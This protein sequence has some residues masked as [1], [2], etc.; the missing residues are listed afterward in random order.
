MCL[1][2]ERFP[3]DD[4][5]I[6]REIT[7]NSRVA[8]IAHTPWRI[9]RVARPDRP[10]VWLWAFRK[11]LQLNYARFEQALASLGQQS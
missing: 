4:D 6:T 9:W 2:D 5:V 8:I 11:A 7:D 10:A 1:L 3:Q